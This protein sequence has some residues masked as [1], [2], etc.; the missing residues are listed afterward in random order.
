M[1]GSAASSPRRIKIALAVLAV[2]TAGIVLFVFL[3]QQPPRAPVALAALSFRALDGWQGSDAGPALRAF[4]RSCAALAAMPA[5]R[6][7]GGAGYAGHVSDWKPVCSEAVS[8]SEPRARAWF[9]SRFAPFEVTGGDNPGGLFTGYYEPALR[10]SRQRHGSYQEPVYG[11]PDD[12]VTADLGLFHADLAGKHITGRLIAHRLVPFPPRGTIEAQRLPD[13]PVLLY[14]NDPISVFFLHIQGS[15]RV[16][17]DTGGEL[18]LAYAGQNGRPYTPIGRTLVAQGALPRQGLSM[19]VIRAWLQAHPDRARAVM[20][21]DESYVF[22]RELP[23]GDPALGSPGSEG[24]PLT[25]EASLAVDPSIHALGV[26]M[27]VVTT[28]PNA[29]P[30]GAEV[31]FARLCVAQDTGGA[32]KGG[33][34]ADIFWGFGA[35]AEAIAGRLKAPGKLYVLLPKPLAAGTRQ[36]GAST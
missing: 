36:A 2:V 13:A 18:R 27:F 9:E 10:A 8:V 4:R 21:S 15:G 25:P 26:P 28:V 32:I 35:R 7:M 11:L 6:P 16:F 31:R 33:V 30:S 22:F 12:L 1:T 3:R 24:A 23:I 17:L 14:A 5:D 34:R 20:D 19:Q 29:N